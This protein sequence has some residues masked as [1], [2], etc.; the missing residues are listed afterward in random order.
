MLFNK[1][2][3]NINKKKLEEVTPY[4]M[5]A[6]DNDPENTYL[7]SVNVLF[8]YFLNKKDE[9]LKVLNKASDNSDITIKQM[10][11]ILFIEYE[12]YKNAYETIKDVP[13]E[14]LSLNL[15]IICLYNL[16]KYKEVITQADKYLEN[17]SENTDVIDYKNKSLEKLGI[18]IKEDDKEKSC[19]NLEYDDDKSNKYYIKSEELIKKGKYEK[20]L[21]CIEKGLEISPNHLSLVNNKILVLIE[22][23]RFDEAEKLQ[24]LIFDLIMA[25][26]K[27]EGLLIK[28][29]HKYFAGDYK[30]C[31]ELCYDLLDIDKNNRDA[32]YFMVS[33]VY[34][35]ENLEELP[36]VLLRI[37]NYEGDDLFSRSS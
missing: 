24:D 7:R 21:K 10:K 25:K 20:A 32:I 4:L 6:L 31:I 36:Q 12:D 13:D 16:E 5:K 28:A 26:D 27:E 9:A 37:T 35:L 23:E 15:K 30:E 19:E 33:S 2:S 14:R 29:I 18:D 22:L 1:E 34:G 17:Y 8:L 3:Q 11:A